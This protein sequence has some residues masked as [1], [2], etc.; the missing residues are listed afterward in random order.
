MIYNFNPFF[1]SKISFFGLPFINLST[2]QTTPAK[3]SIAKY[4]TM[5][6]INRIVIN[7]ITFLFSFFSLSFRGFQPRPLRG[8]EVL[9]VL[10][11]GFKKDKSSG[12]KTIDSQDMTKFWAKQNK[13][14]MKILCSVSDS[15]SF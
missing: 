1:Q 2:I 8:E 10:P 13:R 12:L 6:A 3:E 14:P 15:S 11:L 9:D 7:V 5:Y 4:T